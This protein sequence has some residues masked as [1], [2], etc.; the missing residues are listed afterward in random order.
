MMI[1]RSVLTYYLAV[2]AL[3]I[4]SALA[5]GGCASNPSSAATLSRAQRYTHNLAGSFTTGAATARANNDN[6][7]AVKFDE[8][9]SWALAA[10]A[11]VT[12]AQ[13]NGDLE[14]AKTALMALRRRA[15]PIKDPITAA[16]VDFGLAT[17][18]DELSLAAQ[19][20]PPPPPP[21]AP[22]A[23]TARPSQ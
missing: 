14:A 18:I 10:E 9:A 8:A 15:L 3:T 22:P 20:P 13:G 12:A 2:A 16:T 7:T 17:F 21:P 5:L 23:P 1:A 19:P 4:C 6:A 11:A